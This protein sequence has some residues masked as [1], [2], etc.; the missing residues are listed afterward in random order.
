[1]YRAQL[2]SKSVG[3]RRWRAW[4]RISRRFPNGLETMIG[5]RG[6]TLSGGQKQRA[7]IARAIL[8]NPRILILDDALS[9]VDTVTE[10]KIVTGLAG[11]MRDR[12]T[13][14][15]SHRVSTVQNADRIVVLSH[16]TIVETGAARRTAAAWRLLR[17]PV[18]KTVT[19]RGTRS[20]LNRTATRERHSCVFPELDT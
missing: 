7:A 11:I 16:G 18:S 1:M 3:Q 10:E 2:W 14:L 17:R 6:L 4:D 13:I 5:E 15:I 12:T 20:D 8:R 19:R 9:S